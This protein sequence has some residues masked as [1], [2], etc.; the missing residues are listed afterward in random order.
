MILTGTR[1]LYYDRAAQENTLCN[2]PERLD[3]YV[4][5]QLMASSGVSVQ[6]DASAKNLIIESFLV[7][8][9]PPDDQVQP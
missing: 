8:R 7:G 1:A 2:L 5:L 6:C 9:D 4:H 3:R